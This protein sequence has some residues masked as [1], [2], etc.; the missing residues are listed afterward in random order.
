MVD[1]SVQCIYI[2]PCVG[3]FLTTYRDYYNE[4][5]KGLYPMECHLKWGFYVY[6]ALFFVTYVVGFIFGSRKNDKQQK[7]YATTGNDRL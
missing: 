6:L 7:D 3:E 4:N 1:I 5:H 2:F